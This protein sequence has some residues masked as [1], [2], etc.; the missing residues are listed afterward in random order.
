MYRRHIAVA[1][2]SNECRVDEIETLKRLFK[3]ERNNMNRNMN[4]LFF[5]P[6]DTLQNL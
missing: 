5:S 1:G 4:S 6:L 3:L 2:N